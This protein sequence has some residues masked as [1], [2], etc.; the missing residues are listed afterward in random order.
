MKIEEKR[1]RWRPTR[2]GFLIGAG[3]TGIGLAL[4]IG[5]GVPYGQLQLARMLDSGSAPSSATT[6]PF[7]W[8]EITPDNRIRLFLSKVE[9]GQGIHT[10]L[11]QIGAE[12]LEVDWAQLEIVQATTHVG[13]TDR[14]GTS[15]SN[16]V[17]G[18]YGPLRQAA[19]TLREML[20]AEAALAL[21]EQPNRLL[22][23]RGRFRVADNPARQISY[24]EIVAHHRQRAGDTWET[25]E[26]APLKDSDDFTLIGRSLPRV[27]IPDKVT[28]A[29]IYGYDARLEG[30]LYG[31]VLRPPGLEGKVRRIAAGDASTV[32]GVVQVVIE[33][34]FAGVV[35]SSRDAARAAVSRLDVEWDEGKRW[36]QA[37]LE[38]L[39][40][41]GRGN[42]VTVQRE[43]DAARLLR[44][45]AT[46]QAEYRTPLAAHASMEPQ[47]ALAYVTAE[48]ATI[49]CSTQS[50]NLIQGR[51][52]SALKM[53]PEQVEVIPTYLGGGFG[54]KVEADASLEAALLSKAVGAPVHVGWNRT[55][56]MRHGYFRPP[57]HSVLS[58]RLDDAGRMVALEH[59][60]ASSDVAFS[61][62]P[63]IVATVM[64]A[65]FGAWRGATLHYNGVP[66]RQTI[67]WHATMPV[68]TGWWRGLGLLANTFA[69]ESFVDEL[70][71]LAG[72]DPL[73]FRLAHLAGDDFGRRM[74]AV[75][76]LAAE[77]ANWGGAL[78]EGHGL[79]IACCTDV[80][81]VVAQVAEVSLDVAGRV[82]VHN[83]WAAMD[84]GL[85]INPDGAAAQVEGSVM[86]AL[87]STLLEEVTVENGEIV[88]GN[89]DRYPL[90][91]MRQAPHVEV[92]LLEAP[93]RRPRGVGEP[94]MGPVAAAV[95]NALYTATGKRVRRLPITPER[96]ASA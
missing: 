62:L 15:G 39:V 87:S 69:I 77:M 55:E 90:L 66:N 74:A 92:A 71:Y 51:I 48:K 82:R 8:F 41:V 6:E 53:K 3:V 58:G 40:A 30:T 37:E 27:D 73:A 96:V 83:V 21:S 43:G 59:R 9:M 78:P 29:T 50:Q 89:F 36:Q 12:E 34:G 60:Q 5:V 70:A 33:D 47:A 79:G 45:G 14:M 20:R 16:S 81:T 61:M 52:A 67:A 28:G 64:G 35:A 32:D 44:E 95:A 63:G 23:Y 11:A 17:S 94:P 56:E 85:V 72:Q 57:T 24:G 65:D 84:P 91:S 19:A 42:G 2:R 1:S 25:V 68:R 80:D 18:L 76:N 13:P 75:L 86:M 31:A 26:G 49:W 93:D 22:A 88:P 10:A 46:F 4:G 54:R 38:A 7:A